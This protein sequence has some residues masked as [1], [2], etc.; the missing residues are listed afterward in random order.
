MKK[1]IPGLILFLLSAAAGFAQDFTALWPAG[2]M[3]NSKGIKLEHIEANQR[4]T[5]MAEPGFYSFLPAAEDNKG[6]A[7]LVLPSGGYHHLTYN[8]GGFQV[9]KWF[10]TLGIPAFVLN[11][12]LPTSPDLE[13]RYKGPIQDAQRAMKIIRANA[14]KYNIDPDRIG[15]FGTSAGGHLAS[16]LGTHSGDFSV[17]ENDSLAEVY[18]SPAFMI[19][20]SPVISFGKYAH[21]GSLENLLGKSSSEELKEE[22][23]ND[24]Q[25]TEDTPP[26]FLVHAQNDPVVD[27][28]NSILFYQALLEHQVTASLHVFPQGKHV[29][30]IINDSAFTDEWKSLCAEWLLEMGLIN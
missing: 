16:T 10:N 13:I 11:Y 6:A 25:V 4:I 29:I 27:P 22:Y 17:I 24:L 3:P 7:V 23:S 15:V 30:G 14:K 12:R 19:L 18:F 21:E 28:M 5:Q 20:V 26:S 2:K 9:A 1:L 8:L